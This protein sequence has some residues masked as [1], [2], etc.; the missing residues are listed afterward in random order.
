MLK[1]DINSLKQ[2]FK[3]DI[4]PS[5]NPAMALSIAL[6]TRYMLTE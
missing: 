4:K 5:F 1:S 6:L 3:L 2:S